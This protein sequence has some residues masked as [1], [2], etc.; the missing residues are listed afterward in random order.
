VNLA[1]SIAKFPQKALLHD[2]SSVLFS[3]YDSAS[4]DAS[5]EQEVM[6]TSKTIIEEAQAGAKR[7]LDGK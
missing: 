2:R 1:L 6:K 5:I 3:A 4:F 7:F